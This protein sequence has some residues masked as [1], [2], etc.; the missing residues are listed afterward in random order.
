MWMRQNG[1]D[2][3]TEVVF[4]RIQDDP[5]IT[6]RVFSTMRLER[7]GKD[8]YKLVERLREEAAR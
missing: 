7:S 5:E 3:A 6:N 2:A 8:L 4:E 1:R